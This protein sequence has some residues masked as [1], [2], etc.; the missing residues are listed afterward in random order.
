MADNRKT[1][2][3][4]IMAAAEAERKGGITLEEWTDIRRN[5]TPEEIAEAVERMAAAGG[6]D[7]LE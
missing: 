3:D 5:G 7:N 2:L 4:F 6:Y 1:M